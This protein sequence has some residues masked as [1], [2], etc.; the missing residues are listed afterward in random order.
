[1]EKL[2]AARRVCVCAHVGRGIDMTQSAVSIGKWR[3][4]AAYGLHS[5]VCMH[6][7]TTITTKSASGI[8]TGRRG[9]VAY[10]TGSK[11]LHAVLGHR[12]LR[13]K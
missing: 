6:V 13:L 5:K 12:A 10:Q 1:M 2:G 4:S 9:K 8:T 3:I 7:T 11:G